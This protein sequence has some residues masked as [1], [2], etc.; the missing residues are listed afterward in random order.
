V[1][2]PS[3]E[4]LCGS[5]FASAI[6]SAANGLFG[7][8]SVR[9]NSRSALFRESRFLRGAKGDN[10]A[11]RSATKAFVTQVGANVA[12]QSTD[13]AK[14]KQIQRFSGYSHQISRHRAFQQCRSV[15]P[16]LSDCLALK[17]DIPMKLVPHEMVFIDA[18][19]RTP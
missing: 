14:K 17:C 16:I 4:A 18:N 19:E 6:R 10:V 8:D 5:S 13:S 9:K 15:P 3:L 12:N 2:G 1:R 7:A 11:R